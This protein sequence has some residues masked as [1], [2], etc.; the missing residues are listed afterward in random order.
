[1]IAIKNKGL[2]IATPIVEDV[3][4]LG[5]GNFTILGPN[6]EDYD[7]LIDYSVV[8]KLEYGDNLFIFTGDAEAQAETEVVNNGLDIKANLLKVSHHGSNTSS[9]DSFLN[10]VDPDFAVITVGAEELSS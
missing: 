7:N 2:K 5:D 8:L 6:K 4:D 3:Y 9:I 1:M 10:K